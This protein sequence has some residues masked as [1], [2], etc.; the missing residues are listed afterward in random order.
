MGLQ[1]NGNISGSLEITGPAII[2]TL[3]QIPS[4][5]TGMLAVSS[6]DGGITHKLYFHNGDV[7]MEVAFI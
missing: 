4:G 1:F 6:S 7:W 2:T 3:D 5:S